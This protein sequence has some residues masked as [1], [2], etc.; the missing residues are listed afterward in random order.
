MRRIR[1][2]VKRDSKSGG[3][4][5][6]APLPG[7]MR[8]EHSSVIP[9]SR[10]GSVAVERSADKGVVANTIAANPRTEESEGE[11]SSATASMLMQRSKL[12]Q[13]LTAKA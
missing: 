11:Q 5:A 7:A 9:H 1:Y 13:S 10:L 8:L 6:A 3:R 4:K 12:S 2:V